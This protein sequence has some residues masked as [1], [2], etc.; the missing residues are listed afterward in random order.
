MRIFWNDRGGFDVNLRV[1][2]VILEGKNP[3]KIWPKFLGK[4]VI[5]KKGMSSSIKK[6]RR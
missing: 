2:G 6:F 5:L 1:L 3:R 4:T